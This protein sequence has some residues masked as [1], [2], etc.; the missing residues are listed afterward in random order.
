[1]LGK[2]LNKK[3]KQIANR[4]LAIQQQLEQY[5]R[6]FNLNQSLII[7]YIMFDETVVIIAIVERSTNKV[8]YGS[9]EYDVKLESSVFYTRK[10]QKCHSRN[11][12]NATYQVSTNDGVHFSFVKPDGTVA[13]TFTSLLTYPEL[14]EKTQ[15]GVLIDKVLYDPINQ[16]SDGIKRKSVKDPNATPEMMAKIKSLLDRL[17]QYHSSDKFPYHVF[18]DGQSGQVFTVAIE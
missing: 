18:M 9:H 11:S 16:V 15:R 4:A 5:K 8:I 12:S 17:V 6:L 2:L 3:E 1:M 13:M 7:I 10:G 14:S